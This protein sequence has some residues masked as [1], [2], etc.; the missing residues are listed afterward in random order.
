MRP[1][2]GELAIGG[3]SGEAAL[4][5]VRGLELPLAESQ[6]EATARRVADSRRC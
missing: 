3:E 1:K 6:M 4:T 5:D 2:S